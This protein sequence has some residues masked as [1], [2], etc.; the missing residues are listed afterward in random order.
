ML[1]Q[2]V[3]LKLDLTPEAA[4][5]LVGSDLL[6]AD[7][8]VA[9]LRSVYF[10]TEG[11]D[12]RA[13]GFTLRIRKTGEQ[14]VQTVKAADASSAGLFARPE[15]EQPVGDDVPLLDDTTP[16]KTLLGTSRENLGPVFEVTVERRTWMVSSGD[17]E[18]ELALDRG[19]VVAGDRRTPV[20]EIEAELKHGSPAALFSFARRID[21]VAPLRL[22]VLNKAER[23]YRL[24]GPACRA[25]KAE[26]VV[27]AP[28]M[29]AAAAFRHIAGAC[30]RQ[31]R[32]NEALLDHRNG[33]AVHQARVALRRLR[34][35]FTIH[36]A[37]AMDDQFDRLSDELRWLAAELGPARDLDVL[38]AR[39]DAGDVRDRLERARK[40]AY[41]DAATTLASSRTR[42]LML[43]LSQWI[44]CGDWLTLSSAAEA[45]EQPVR[46]FAASALDRFRRKVRKGG[47]GLG[48]LDDVA[49]HEVRK[50]AKK[51]RYAAQFFAS[52]FDTKRQKR[53]HGRF[54]ET[55]EDLQ[56]KLGELNDAVSVAGVLARIGLDKDPAAAFLMTTAGEKQVL[57]EAAAEAH[58]AFA[59]AKRFCGE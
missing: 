27:L 7:P 57:I 10:D 51:L 6:P 20:C 55:L 2:E 45:R 13:A 34:S 26:P 50:D 52:L 29:T 48:D 53:R 36:K 22:G 41:E 44:A 14:R 35:A 12:L 33:E 32:L 43:D 37:I 15:W 30:L 4:D 40:Q 25:V 46:D 9:Q 3:E 28:E 21:A 54:L 5:A 19:E 59:D 18:F 11:Q 49:R 31:F 17:A 1:A 23:G 16:L 24:L 39:C 8:S 58:D 42:G 56:E 47:R 38:I